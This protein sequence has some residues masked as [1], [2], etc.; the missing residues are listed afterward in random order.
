MCLGRITPSLRAV[1]SQ[2][3][4]FQQLFCEHF[5]CSA[6]AY[7]K[8]LFWLALYRH[9]VPVAPVIRWLNPEFFRA[10]MAAIRQF[11]GTTS[12]GEFQKEVEDYSYHIR[13]YG[14]WLQRLLRVR[15]SGHRLLRICGVVRSG[16]ARREQN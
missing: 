12:Y 1:E 6:E 4:T 2:R 10:D 3:K 15:I 9:S 11:G 5:K 13:S 7:E 14:N 16:F 8:K